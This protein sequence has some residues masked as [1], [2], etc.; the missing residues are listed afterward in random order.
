MQHLLSRQR[1]TGHVQ[2]LV[3]PAALTATLIFAPSVSA[4]AEQLVALGQGKV[5]LSE[6]TTTKS[7]SSPTE[8]API[9]KP[10]KLIR[11]SSPLASV[12]PGGT[13]ASGNQSTMLSAPTAPAPST[14]T[15]TQSNDSTTQSSTAS[16]TVAPTKPTST[17]TTAPATSLSFAG[18]VSSPTTSL[19]SSSA[20]VSAVATPGSSNKGGNSTGGRGMNKLSTA[21]P[22]LTQ[23]LEPTSTSSTTTSSTPSTPVIGRNPASMSFSAI[24]GGANPSSQTVTITNSGSGTLGW[25]ANSSAAWLTINGG[26]AASGTNAG[27]FSVGVN[28]SGLSVGSYSGNMVIAASGASNTP[29]S[30]PVT[31]SITAAPTPTIG[32][33]AT[34]LSF[35]GVQGGSNPSAQALTISNSGAG[36][37]NWSIT[38]NAPW[39][40]PSILSGSGAGSVSLAVNTAGMSAGTYSTPVTIAATGATNTPQSVMVTLTVTAPLIPTIGLAPSTLTF[41]A[42]QGGTNPVAQTV[43]ISNSGTG[44]LSWNASSTASWLSVSPPSGTGSGSLAV[45]ANVTGLSPGTYNTAITVTGTGATNSPQSIPVSFTVAA[46]ATTL[47]VG[48]P[49][50][51]FTATQG[52][53]N[54]AAQSLSITSNVA[55]S[56]S[57]SVSWLT[58]GPA[59]GSNNGMVT[60][61]VDTTTATVGTNTGII[62][63]TG[64]GLTRTVNVTLTLSAPAPTLTVG[65]SSLTFSGTQGAA[66]PAAQSLAI[67]SN[68]AW[69]V[70]NSVSWLTLSPASGSNNGTV[71]VSV[72]VATATV[73]TNTGTITVTGSGLTRTVTVTLTLTAAPTTLN[74]TPGSLTFTAT[75]GAAN[76]VNQTL[77]VTSNTNWTVSDNVG[78]LTVNPASASNNGNITVSINTATATA[79]TNVATI[80][81]TGGGVT[82]TVDVTLTLNAASTSSAT[83]TWTPNTETDMASYKIYQSTTQ[84]IYGTAIA[85]V[86]AGTAS[87]TVT[88]LPLGSTYYFRITAV[89]SS[90]NESLPSN[91]VSKS[92]F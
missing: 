30:I 36:T 90:G 3:A 74:V 2:A 73:G 70:S 44:T 58:V 6:N 11:K 60:V 39:L 31:L 67:T 55:W 23:L 92:I 32:L 82:K 77:A 51:A 66:N 40:T 84:G 26:T 89:D 83:L 50:L 48:S 18:A 49:S 54:P 69:S 88:G 29:Q 65:S 62:T 71:T 21:M 72:D 75:Q 20:P 76:P 59:S 79:G 68:V 47:T 56:V 80:T 57:D 28:I 43:N 14:T 86:P 19:S 81:L 13:T 46:P 63:V 4:L 17:T 85:T 12:Q 15:Q 35:N 87:Y 9:R 25:S 24:Q 52:A 53:G 1:L 61:T 41:S 16:T 10:H 45:T 42:N 33:S 64:G 37:L 38:E 27:S 34:S 8:S 78:W 91:E 22:G 5:Q 7:S